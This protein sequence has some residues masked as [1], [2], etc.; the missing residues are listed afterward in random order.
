MNQSRLLLLFPVLIG[1][2]VLGQTVLYCVA[3][4]GDLIRIDK[5]TGAGTLIGN[6]GVGANGAAADPQGR[7]LS[8]GGN[9][10]QIIQLDPATGA[11]TVF[12]TTTG[13][14]FGYGIRGMAFDPSG[15]SW[16]G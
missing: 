6:S 8:G 11:G 12:L 14:P 9:A 4:N 3:F 16:S 5:A 2:P 1:A 10:D 13:R 7:I 15:R